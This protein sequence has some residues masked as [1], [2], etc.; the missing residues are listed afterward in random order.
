MFPALVNCCTIDWFTE[1]PSEALEKVAGKFL[2]E[3]DME[4]DVRRN[5]VVMCGYFHESVRQVS[6]G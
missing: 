2:E 5:C 3:M 4:D 6:S 1:W